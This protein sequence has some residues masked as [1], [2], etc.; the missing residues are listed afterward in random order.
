[1]SSNSSS[2]VIFDEDFAPSEQLF[3]TPIHYR[4][5]IIVTAYLLAALEC[6][7]ADAV[8]EEQTG[9][10]EGAR[11]APIRESTDEEDGIPARGIGLERSYFEIGFEERFLE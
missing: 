3:V 1:M 9:T 10:N 6:L 4:I 2:S 5:T 8:D 11:A 7:L